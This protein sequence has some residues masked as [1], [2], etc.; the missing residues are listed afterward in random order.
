M[1]FR[2]EKLIIG[3]FAS[4]VEAGT[5][6]GEEENLVGPDFYP[7]DTEDLGVYG[8][9][10]CVLEAEPEVTEEDDPDYCPSLA[11]GYDLEEDPTVVKDV[12]KMSL[13]CHSEPIWR[14]IWGFKNKIV[15]GTPQTPFG[16][17]KRYV[18]GW[19]IFEQRAGDGV[20][21]MNA[22]IYGRLRLDAAPKWSKDPTKPAVRFEKRYSSIATGEP[23]AIAA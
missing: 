21:K 20:T 3:N 18:E 16:S 11:G 8:S 15:N 1:A 7:E 13:K 4:F 9:L 22:A 2:L 14:L 6:V 10:G 17:K 19:L 23:G 5:V 12:I